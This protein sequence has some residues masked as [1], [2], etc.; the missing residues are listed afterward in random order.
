MRAALPGLDADLARG[1]LSAPTAWLRKNVQRHGGLYEPR[2]TITRACGAE[3]DAEP[4]L[5]YL[6]QKFG[7]LYPG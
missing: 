3:P 5:A 7:A 1:D 2:E 6:E 4:L